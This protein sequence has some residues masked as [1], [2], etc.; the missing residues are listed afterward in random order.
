MLIIFIR[1]ILTWFSGAN[2]GRPMEILCNITD[3]YLNWFRRFNVLKTG[4]IDISPI[5]AMATLSILYNILTTLAR[6]G[7]ITLGYILAVILSSLWSVG[8]FILGFFIVVLIIRAI[9]TMAKL[10]KHGNFWRI[11]DAMSQPVLYRINRLF[12][13]RRI[14][15]YQVS[16]LASIAFLGVILLIMNFLMKELIIFCGGLPI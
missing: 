8:S 11:I 4:F 5:F 16:I 2:Y 3:P 1:I 13:K 14:V 7:T 15:H 10:N 6:Y 12:F 9:F